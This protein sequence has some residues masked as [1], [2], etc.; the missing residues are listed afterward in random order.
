MDFYEVLDK[1]ASIR[2]YQD[3]P[4]EPGKLDRILEA[5][6][7]APS[8]GN[9]QAYDI[10]VVENPERKRELVAAAFGQSFIAEAPVVLVISANHER[11]ASRYGQRGADLYAIQDATIATTY[12]HLAAVAEGLSSCWVGAFDTSEVVRVCEIPKDRIPVAMLP[13]GHPAE[14][15]QKT[16]RRPADMAVSHDCDL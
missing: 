10:L 2:S 9:L 14:N 11:S 1:R 16:G 6:I 13:I 7:S 3:K 8:A 5:V 15:T 12:A 4:V